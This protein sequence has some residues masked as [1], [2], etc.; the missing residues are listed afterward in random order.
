ML[1]YSM[2]APIY[3]TRPRAP[4]HCNPKPKLNSPNPKPSPPKPLTV[5]GALRYSL[6]MDCEEHPMRFGIRGLGCT[7]RDVNGVGALF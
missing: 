1:M 5:L 6:W 7:K 2:L 3:G 4:G